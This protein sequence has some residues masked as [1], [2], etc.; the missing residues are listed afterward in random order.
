MLSLTEAP[1][2]PHNVARGTFIEIDGVVQPA[3][4]PRFSRTQ[5]VTP[6]GPALPGDHT[7]EVLAGLGLDD[8]AI[9]RLIDSGIARQSSN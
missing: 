9:T 2:H 8:E 4:A 5:P 7:R 6:T 3:P 1:R